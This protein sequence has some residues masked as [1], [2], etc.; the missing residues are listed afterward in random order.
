MFRNHAG[1]RFSDISVLCGS[2]LGGYGQGA[3]AGDFD[4]DGFPDLFV[5]NYGKDGGF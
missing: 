4:G 5:S 3:A 2:D 1:K